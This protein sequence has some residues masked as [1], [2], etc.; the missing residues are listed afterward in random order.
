[1]EL[2]QIDVVLPSELLEVRFRRDRSAFPK[3][4]TQAGDE[5]VVVRRVLRTRLDLGLPV[6]LI[7]MFRELCCL[8]G[9]MKSF[10]RVIW[11]TDAQACK[12]ACDDQP[13]LDPGGSAWRGNADLPRPP[14]W[15]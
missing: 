10:D 7:P 3:E 15:L 6:R 5:E 4:I 2:L 13:A 8:S 11:C 12:F 14:R 1:M 9:T